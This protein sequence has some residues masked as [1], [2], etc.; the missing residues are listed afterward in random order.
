MTN[1]PNSNIYTYQA[2]AARARHAGHLAGAP[3]GLVAVVGSRMPSE[4][5]KSALEASFQRLGYGVAPCTWVALEGVSGA[6]AGV[7]G[8]ESAGETVTTE[9]PAAALSTAELYGLLEA[10]DPLVLVATDAAAGRALGAVYRAEF[11]AMA[12]C[13]ALGRSVV[14]LPRPDELLASQEGKQRLWTL[15][16]QLGR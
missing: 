15:L 5:V 2:D 1:S 10:L 16:K 7:H 8:G 4:A 9:T 6:A 12:H 14:V 3:Q 11:K 13:R